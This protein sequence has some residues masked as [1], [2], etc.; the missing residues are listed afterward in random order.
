MNDD[1]P[2]TSSP[3]PTRI[4]L[5]CMG[6]SGAYGKTDD[7]QSIA[8]IQAAIE[9]GVTF[10]DTG[11]FY[12]SGHNELLI[13]KAI[14]G[15]RDRVQLSVKFGMLRG[16]DNS[17]GGVDAR[18]VAVKN[19]LAYSL[20]RLGTDHVD[21]YR[22]AR[23]DPAVPIEDTI[24]AIADLVKAGYVR[25]IGLSEV[26][27]DTIRRAAK[28]H[29]I[30]DLQIEYSI[31]SRDPEDAIFPALAELGIGATLYGVLS[32][33]LLSASPIGAG[34]ARARMPRFSEGN[35]E[36]NARLVTRLQGL[37]QQWGITLSQLA[38]GWVLGRQPRF[39]PTLGMRTLQQLDEALAAK[40]LTAGQ[41]AEVEAIMP[42][43]AIAG[44]RYPAAHLTSLDSEKR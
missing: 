22:P 12:G 37:A 36:A 28:V 27:P 40:P 6:M 2:L 32:R 21:V 8:V 38:I 42:R 39:V 1:R 41:R 23:L 35:R 26:G 34:D 16:P 7:A 44:T 10:L 31:A 3:L 29:P 5:G 24:G 18:P 11:D 17:L 9:R 19:F 15:R 25:S 4:A 14:A 43:G 30:A 33:G 13:G 20:V